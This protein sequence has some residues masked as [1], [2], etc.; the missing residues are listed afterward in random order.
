MMKKS[1]AG[2]LALILVLCLAACSSG[3]EAMPGLSW[4]AEEMVR[5]EAYTGQVPTDSQK[6][7]TDDGEVIRSLAEQVLKM[8]ASGEATIDDVPDS[9]IGLYLKFI[10]ADGSSETVHFSS[11][12]NLL[13]TGTGADTQEG[14][15]GFFK[16]KESFDCQAAWDSIPGEESAI[17]PDDLPVAGSAKGE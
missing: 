9:G 12:G 15:I 16:L 5:L 7:D 4:K 1:V 11:D 2:I 14:S 13:A 3:S 8:Q 10:R 17:S 6:K